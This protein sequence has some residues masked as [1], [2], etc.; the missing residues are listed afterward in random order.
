M[1]CTG[2]DLG[3]RSPATVSLSDCMSSAML[4]CGLSAARLELGSDT[5]AAGGG[6]VRRG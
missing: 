1:A 2:T 3:G 4:F 5:A 6:L